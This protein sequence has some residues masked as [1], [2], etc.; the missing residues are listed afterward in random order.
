[1]ALWR[2]GECQAAIENLEKADQMKGGGGFEIW[3]YTSRVPQPPAFQPQ[4]GD[5]GTFVARMKRAK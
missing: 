4:L 3:Q 5:L 1:M 2:N